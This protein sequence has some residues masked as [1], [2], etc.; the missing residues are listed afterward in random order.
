MD[1]PD[2]LCNLS[3]D[4]FALFIFSFVWGRFN[5]ALYY[6]SFLDAKFGTGFWH[7][8]SKKLKKRVE[9]KA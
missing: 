3:V 2:L 1:A 8:F 9:Y 6:I 7:F 4:L 5:V